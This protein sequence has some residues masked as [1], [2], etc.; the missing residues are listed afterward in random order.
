MLWSI[1]Y[2]VLE[3]SS[4]DGWNALK[5]RFS[6]QTG[7]YVNGS[8]G[9]SWVRQRCSSHRLQDPHRHQVILCISRLQKTN[10]VLLLVTA[11]FLVKTR[12]G[13]VSAF[14]D[15]DPI[16]SDEISNMGIRLTKDYGLSIQSGCL[17]L[18][19]LVTDRLCSKHRDR[20]IQNMTPLLTSE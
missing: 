8:E 20:V 14:L 17:L 5:W 3:H 1:P 15:C 4:H 16:P 10:S 6:S 12:W 2:G 9:Q 18:Y 13:Q 19:E 11:D 7:I